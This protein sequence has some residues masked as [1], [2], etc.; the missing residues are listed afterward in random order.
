M[1]H[2]ESA[3]DPLGAGPELTLQLLYLTRVAID[4]KVGASLDTVLVDGCSVESS[5]RLSLCVV[6]AQASGLA[7]SRDLQPTARAQQQTSPVVNSS[8]MVFR[9]GP[10]MVPSCSST[11]LLTCARHLPVG[12][13]RVTP[14]Y[15]ELLPIYAS[16]DL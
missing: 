13:N 1:V 8:K 5:S 4:I 2:G 11:V 9:D 15:V 12:R 14:L 7:T 6:I 16:N 10:Q 3:A